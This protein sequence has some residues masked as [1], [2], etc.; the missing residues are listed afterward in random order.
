MAYQ[1][2]NINDESGSTYH[3]CYV[4]KWR[5]FSMK[6]SNMEC[7][8][9]HWPFF[10]IVNDGDAII[11]DRKSVINC[12]DGH[13]IP[14]SQFYNEQADTFNENSIDN[15]CHFPVVTRKVKCI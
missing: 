1:E 6:L 11:S 9:N 3:V 7:T 13:H 12:K 4:R 5:L 14:S 10:L 8:V 15:S 2:N